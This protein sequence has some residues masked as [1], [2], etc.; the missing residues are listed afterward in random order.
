MDPGGEESERERDK[1]KREEQQAGG[2][3]RSRVQGAN[4]RPVI[5]LRE[6]DSSRLLGIYV[7]FEH[8]KTSQGCAAAP[9]SRQAR[10]LRFFSTTNQTLYC[11]LHRRAKKKLRMESLRGAFIATHI[12][13]RGNKNVFFLSVSRY[14]ALPWQHVE[15]A[16]LTF[17][18]DVDL[19]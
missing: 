13:R 12:P 6:R 3:C 17:S 1:T 8:T 18:L 2:L 5:S 4:G 14:Y 16:I 15:I 10:A 7:N 19:L 9:R 11:V